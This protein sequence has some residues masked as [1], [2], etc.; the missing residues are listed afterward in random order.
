MNA[1]TLLEFFARMTML[2]VVLWEIQCFVKAVVAT[3]KA[4][5]QYRNRV[6]RCTYMWNSLI[7]SDYHKSASNVPN[8]K[9]N[10]FSTIVAS[11]VFTILACFQVLTPMAC[12]GIA[13]FSA[14]VFVVGS[15]TFLKNNKTYIFTRSYQKRLEQNV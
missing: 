11:S 6:L 2:L 14:L 13:F 12:L 3:I 5:I 10:T 15:H 9:I 8:F 4:P 1:I 7:F